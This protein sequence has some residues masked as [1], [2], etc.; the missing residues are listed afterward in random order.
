M[1]TIDR[2]LTAEIQYRQHRVADSYTPRRTGLRAFPR[3]GRRLTAG[4]SR[5]G[6]DLSGVGGTVAAAR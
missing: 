2:S 6:T 5:T 4:S 3:P 1:F